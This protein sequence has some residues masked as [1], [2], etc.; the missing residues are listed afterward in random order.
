MTTC[1]RP[2]APASRARSAR[3]APRGH[4]GT[5][6]ATAAT[7]QAGTRPHA[8]AGTARSAGQGRP[9]EV[10]SRGQ[11]MGSER[12]RSTSC[13]ETRNV[14]SSGGA[15]QVILFTCAAPPFA[16]Q[17]R[18]DDGGSVA[19]GLEVPRERRC[20][21]RGGQRAD[22]MGAPRRAQPTHA[23]PSPPARARARPSPRTRE[24]IGRPSPPRPP[25]RPQRARPRRRP[26]PHTSPSPST[27]R[28]SRRATSTRTRPGATGTA[29][30]RT[31]TGGTATT[32][33]TSSR[34]RITTRSPTPRS[35]ACSNARSASCSSPAR[36]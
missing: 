12:A 16:R 11:S 36:R 20:A 17:C 22:G 14:A 31:S 30:P 29:R 5:H 7:T 35:S 34:S 13:D 4:E 9:R 21:R 19:N 1:A 26:R 3:H 15:R 18:R 32:A 28:P 24:R 6:S 10:D 2:G 8:C 33:T 27:S 23:A 25:R